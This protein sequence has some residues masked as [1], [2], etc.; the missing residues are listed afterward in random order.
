MELIIEN[1]GQITSGILATALI[2]FTI[3]SLVNKN[4][5][6][7]ID[8]MNNRFDDMNNRLDSIERTVNEHN[9][10]IAALNAGMTILTQRAQFSPE[11]TS[12]ARP[13]DTDAPEAAAG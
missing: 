13:A 8:D 11:P 7:R 4:T 5:D 1:I 9:T 10:Q 3:V 2:I 12:G 6:K